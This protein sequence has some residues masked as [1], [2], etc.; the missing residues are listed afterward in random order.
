MVTSIWGWRYSVRTSAEAVNFLLFKTFL[1]NSN[2]Y[3]I[4]RDVH[5]GHYH[6]SGFE[7]LSG[8]LSTYNIAASHSLWDKTRCVETPVAQSVSSS[9]C[10]SD[11]SNR[12]HRLLSERELVQYNEDWVYSETGQLIIVAATANETWADSCC[13]MYTAEI[14]CRDCGGKLR[15]IMNR[16]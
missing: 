14:H 13:Q 6:L 15:I 9:K 7:I 10:C 12:K 1:W 16:T 8:C 5:Q 3:S 2:K 4:P 11:V